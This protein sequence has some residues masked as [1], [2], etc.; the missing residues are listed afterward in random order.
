MS[1]RMNAIGM[2][3]IDLPAT[4]AFYRALGLDIPA[5]A[6]TAPHVEVDL[7]G[8][9]KLM[10]D[11]E[12][13]IRSFAPEYEPPASAGRIGICFEF[14]NPA[15]V[16]KTYAALTAAGHQGDKAPWDADWGQ[17]YAIIQDPDGNGVSLYARLP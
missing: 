17:R 16:D 1:A 15:E 10:W 14:D 12:E 3:A 4:L 9:V 8:G 11:S 2:I 7:G 6:D 13:T 5:E